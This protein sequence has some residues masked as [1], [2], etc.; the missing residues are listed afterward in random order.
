M[1]VRCPTCHPLPL[2]MDSIGIVEGQLRDEDGKPFEFQ[3]FDSHA[4][5]Q[6]RYEDIGEV[7]SLTSCLIIG[8]AGLIKCVC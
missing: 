3:V 2:V 1:K 6:K 4:D 7:N 5:N 8:Q